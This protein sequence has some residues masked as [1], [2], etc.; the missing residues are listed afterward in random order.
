[1]AFV[2]EEL[3]FYRSAGAYVGWAYGLCE[4]L[5]GHRNAKDYFLR[6]LQVREDPAEYRIETADAD[7]DAGSNKARKQMPTSWCC[8]RLI[9][10]ADYVDGKEYDPIDMLLLIRKT[11]K[12]RDV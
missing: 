4:H 12:S 2:Q 3:G 6:S 8:Q 10:A 9:A 1:M 11:L 5:R 7:S